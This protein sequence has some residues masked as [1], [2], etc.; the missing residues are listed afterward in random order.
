M[1]N[2]FII[3]YSVLS[4]LMMLTTLS[5]AYRA[6]MHKNQMGK[7]LSLT[8]LFGA[9]V[10][11]TYLLSICLSDYFQAS[12][13][14][15]LYFIFID[16]LLVYM[17]AFTTVFSHRKMTKKDKIVYKLLR[18]YAMFE[19]AVF[20]IN[21]FF[22][23]AIHY[24]L[25]M[26]AFARYTYEMMPLYW[27]HLI[28]TYSMVVFILYLLIHK[29]TT[30]PGRYRNQYLYII[31]GITAIV[32]VNAG[33]LF[34]PGDYV[35]ARIDYSIIG[36]AL[37]LA[38]TYWSAFEYASH[39]MLEGLTMTVFS[40]IDQ[41][42]LLFDYDGFLLMQNQKAVKMLHPNVPTSPGMKMYVFLQEIGLWN[43]GTTRVESYSAQ[44]YIP[45][46]NR[47]IPARCDYDC[48]RDEK[49]R[50]IGY[51]YIF[52]DMQ[53][54]TD[55]LTEFHNWDNFCHYVANNP[56]SFM[57]PVSVAVFD[58]NNLGMINSSY[59][60]DVGDQYLLGLSQYIREVFPKDSYFVRRDACLYVLCH[61]ANE[62]ALVA[63]AEKVKAQFRGNLQ[64]AVAVPF[65][66][67]PDIVETFENVLRALRMKKLLDRDSNRSQIL[68]SLVKALQES[69]SDT[70]AH[71]QRTQQ[72]GF[73]LGK[74]IGLSDAQQSELSLLCLLHDI[75]KIGVPLE[76]LNK[77]GRLSA[78][79]WGV[80][81]AHAE[82]GYQIAR[83]SA[84]F[85]SIADA[86][87][88]HHERWDG[89][90]YPAGLSRESIPLL[91]RIIA[92]ID[93]YDAM[94]NDRSY[95]AA[96]PVYVAQQELKKNAGSQFDPYIVSQFM[97]MLQENGQAELRS[98]MQTNEPVNSSMQM[99]NPQ[100]AEERDTTH[101]IQC[102]RYILNQ[103]DVVIWADENFE[104]M[105]GYT[106]EEVQSQTLSQPQL[107]PEEDRANY[108]LLVAEQLGKKS[109][110]YLEHRIQHKD[111]RL[112]YVFCYGK[113]Y[114]DSVAKEERS[115]IIISDSTS[116][117]AVQY[118]TEQEN[119][120][121]Q[122][123][124]EQWEN[125]YRRDPL[126]G[127]SNRAAF[128]SDVEMKLLENK[129][130]VLFIMVD[131][132]HFKDYNDTHG[133]RAGDEYLIQI[134]QA[135]RAALRKD[136]L[137][138]RMGGDEFAIA[139]FFEPKVPEELLAQRAQQI[140]DRINRTLSG[141]ETHTSLSMGAAVSNM[142]KPDNFDN[143]YQRA[144]A[145]LYRSKE[146]GRG[147][148]TVE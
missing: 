23:I 20:A 41:G 26:T 118:Y 54:E 27:G 3:G 92:V 30:V 68:N 31:L 25:R 99:K 134:G 34:L 143:L 102:S 144:D 108:M 28:F 74:R 123:R 86:I 12:V 47:S 105:T 117:C 79:E 91:S 114:Y 53:M 116:T 52:T 120:R 36:Y 124:L 135:L 113:P 66:I 50:I 40:N 16:W 119:D 33:F 97:Q 77:P 85:S 29:T 110:V 138:C 58:I 39:S 100:S 96:L 71:V 62:S 129:E 43:G 94:I 88:H 131:V 125:T 7:F 21:P 148:I 18:L 82:K 73:A 11:I 69:D 60:K 145:A 89:K 78:E 5:V 72:L 38:L 14:S 37:V 128:Q 48:L 142:E 127:L 22:E 139:L 84:E 24:A 67:Q 64:Y 32:L 63:G 1:E 56:D 17:V 136:D 80:L 115:E 106:Q 121:A 44:C 130:R 8:A 98:D 107:I 90:G 51:L 2:R 137:A 9:L 83:S 95:R 61:H 70:E 4:V 76:I 65:G 10:N 126:T 122:K 87:L 13:M 111:G 141:Y 59:G 49:G 19:V 140:F 132:D 112:A 46:E 55:L 101:V 93:A 146:K 35:I 42:I 6:Y 57:A 104:K 75:G 133:H 15:S 81:Q 103:K 109:F 45:K 147:R